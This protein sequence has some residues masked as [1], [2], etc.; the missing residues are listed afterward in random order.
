MHNI[1]EAVISRINRMPTHPNIAAHLFTL[2][3]QSEVD[4]GNIIKLISSDPVL[5]AQILFIANNHFL[6]SKKRVTRVEQAIIIL[7]FQLVQE[8]ILSLCLLSIF[9]S[10]YQKYFRQTFWMHS[11]YTAVSMKVLADNFD[12]VN[13]NLLYTGG[14]LHDIGKMY[15]YRLLG[16][17][18]ELVIQTGIEQNIRLNIAEN[19]VLNTDHCEMGGRLLSQWKLPEDLIN[20]VKYHHHPE[21]FK[22]GKKLDF[23]IRL[24]Y[25]ANV[26]AHL[27][28]KGLSKFDD[29][30]KFDPEFKDYLSITEKSFDRVLGAIKIEI[31]A[32]QQNLKIFGI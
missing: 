5:T 22:S 19:K 7:G 9:E 17:E 6:N 21:A 12:S 27:I 10:N 31:Q 16:K 20:M 32:K 1:E 29:L 3:S 26:L 8:L 23:W 18:Y 2:Y 13:A 15:L 24:V 4:L 14:L 28:E 25:F 11:M 30:T